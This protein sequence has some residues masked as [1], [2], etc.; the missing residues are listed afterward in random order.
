MP[1]AGIFA[2]IAVV[3]LIVGGLSAL[4]LRR[5]EAHP[6]MARRL[7]GPRQVKVGSLLDGELPNRAV[8]VIGRVRCRDPLDTG[9]GEKLVAFHR[10]VDV[11]IGGGWRSLERLRETRSF[12]L[13]DHD[14]SLAV[15]PALAAEPLVTIPKVWRGSPAAL[16]EP[17]ASAVARIEEREG[18]IDLARATTRT[19]ATTDRLMVVA[20]PTRDAAGS[21]RLDP[22]PGGFIV[23]NLELSDAMRILAG[24][25]RRAASGGVV[26][27]G[28]SIALVAIG[29]V[30]AI[31]AIVLGA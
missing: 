2:A 1:L 8:R 9:D 12:D 11:R 29:L 22:P 31:A 4:T 25:S 27:L 3:G 14:G 19:L 17:H 6:G 5:S 28:I 18:R 30:G 16:E 21:V 20:L 15:D 7:A 24:R 23:T 10:D 13:W 26:G